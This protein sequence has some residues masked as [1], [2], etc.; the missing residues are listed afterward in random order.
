[1]VAVGYLDDVITCSED[2]Q[3]A[4][5]VTIRAFKTPVL[6]PTIDALRPLGYHSARR[7]A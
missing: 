7:A 2:Q 3:G 6:S 4:P 5:P 1:V